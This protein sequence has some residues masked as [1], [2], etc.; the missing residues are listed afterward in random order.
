[1]EAEFSFC[2]P[3]TS[4]WRGEQSARQQVLGQAERVQAF[5]WETQGREHGERGRGD[6]GLS[7]LGLSSG[8]RGLAGLPQAAACVEKTSGRFCLVLVAQPVL[9]SSWEE[10]G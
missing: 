1:M 8:S 10:G 2:R 3:I 9:V 6:S 7:L 4:S 5:S